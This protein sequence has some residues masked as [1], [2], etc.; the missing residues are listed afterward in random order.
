MNH[1]L[2]MSLAMMCEIEIARQHPE[3]LPT[4]RQQLNDVVDY[5]LWLQEEP[6]PDGW[7]V[8]LERL[9][10]VASVLRLKIAA[11]DPDGVPWN[12]LTP[13]ERRCLPMLLNGEHHYK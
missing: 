10:L 3:Q 12:F 2:I 8:E 6:R 4:L 13:Y 9:D 11:I 7:E 1:P 5:A